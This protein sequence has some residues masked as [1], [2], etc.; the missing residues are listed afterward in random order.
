[1]NEGKMKLKIFK[2]VV[3]I[4]DEVSV[5]MMKLINDKAFQDENFFLAV[6]GGST[7]VS[8]FKRLASNPFK[9]N[10]NWKFL[11]IFWVDER[12]VP[13]ADEQSNYG[14]TKKYLLDHVEIP[15]ENIHRIKGENN[16]AEEIFRYSSEVKQWVPVKNSI[17]VFDLCLMGMG[18]DGHT[19]SIF[20]GQEL[21]ESVDNVCGTAKHPET[22]QMRI[23]LTF[24][25]LNNCNQ[26]WFLVSGKDKA[27]ILK[28]IYRREPDYLKFPAAMIQPHSG[29]LIWFAD[30]EAAQELS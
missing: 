24:D 30:E 22:G 15:D 9:E 28:K 4:A 26:S 25:T 1:M 13:P 8:L 14:M 17:P 18:A 11:H 16:P 7:P 23:S 2:S 6:S 12:C 20:P 3:E 21:I 27:A 19:A 10:L 5:R 29:N